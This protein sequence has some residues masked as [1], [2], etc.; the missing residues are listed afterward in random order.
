MNYI[1]NAWYVA[2]WASE[3]NEELRR[4]VILEQPMVMFRAS[5][6][7]VIALEDR[8]PHRLLPLSL[9]KRIDDTIQCGYHGMTFDCEGKCVRIPGQDNLPPSAAVVAF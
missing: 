3:F 4:V 6:G 5:D 7:K 8:C 2:G 1:K 9:G